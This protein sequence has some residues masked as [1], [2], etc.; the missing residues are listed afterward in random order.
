[1]FLRKLFI[2]GLITLFLIPMAKS[3]AP[4]YKK[5]WAKIDSLNKKLLPK[6]ALTEVNKLYDRAK[7]DQNDAQLIKTLLYKLGLQDNFTEDAPEK[8]IQQ[9]EKEMT[10]LK[11]PAKSI[12]QNLLAEF[13][14]NYFQNNRF[15]IFQRTNTVDFKKTDIATW[16]TGDFHKKIGQLYKASLKNE[17]L[18]QQTKLETFDAL[19]TKGNARNLRPTLFDLLAHK[20]LDYFNNDE[21]DISRPAYAFEISQA[22]AFAPAKEFIKEKFDTKDSGSLHHEAL[23]LYQRL[24]S[25]HITD[26]NP[27]ALVD[28]DLGRLQFAYLYSVSDNKKELYQQALLSLAEQY[29][30]HS[31]A[32]NALVLL[33]KIHYDNTNEDF[34]AYPDGFVKAKEICDKIVMYKDSSFARQE[35]EIMLKEINS[36]QL[37]LQAERVTLPKQAFRVLVTYKNTDNIFV[38]I[39]SLDKKTKTTLQS[40]HYWENDY[41]EELQKISPINSYQQELPA[42]KDYLQHSAEIKVDGLP[43]GEYAIFTSTE[44]DFSIEKS[45]LAVQYVYISSL[46]WLNNDNDF[47]VVNRESGQPQARTNVQVWYRYYDSQKNSYQKRKG[48][49]LITDK[50]GFFHIEESRTNTNNSFSLELS[51][52]G[53]YLFMD[54]TNINSYSRGQKTEEK[55]SYESFLFTDRS[56]YRPGQILYFKGILISKSPKDGK[57]NI[58]AGHETTISLFDINEQKVDSIIV[59]TN[60]FGSYSGKF[61][62]P[63]GQLTGNFRIQ[64]ETSDYSRYFSVE[65]Y[66]RPKF[67]VTINKPEG[68][69]KLNE[70]INV[71]GTAIGYSGAAVNDAKVSYR[72]VR[73]TILPVWAGFYSRR[74]APNFSRQEMEIA[75]GELKTAADGSFTIPFKAIPDASIDKKQQPIF[76]Y[77]IN[78]DI[79]DINGETRSA[80]TLVSVAYQSVKLKLEIPESLSADSLKEIIV[81]STNMNDLFEKSNLTISIQKLSKPTRFFRSRNWTMPDQFLYKE[82]EYHK[83][84]PFDIYKDEDQPANWKKDGDPITVTTSSNPEG[85]IALNKKMSE[86]WYKI[87]VTTTDKDGSIIKEE[88]TIELT[89]TQITNPLTFGSIES[90]RSR[91]EAGDKL[92]YTIK[93][94]LDSIWVIHNINRINKTPEKQFMPV[95]Q[96]GKSFTIETSEADRGGIAL[97]I[98]FIKNNRVYT[99]NT[100]IAIPFSN[101]E[102]SITYS[103]FRDKTLPGKEEKWKVHIKG[104][105]T[106]KVLAEL[107]TTMYDA[108]LDQFKAHKISMPHLWDISASPQIFRGDAGFNTGGNGQEHQPNDPSIDYIEKQY[109]E[110]PIHVGMRVQMMASFNNAV[111]ILKKVP[112]VEADDNQ[113]MAKFVLKSNYME[114][115]VVEGRIARDKPAP[116]EASIK[117]E[118]PIQIRKNFNE[119]AFFLPDLK[120]DSAGD[121]EFSFTMPEAL[122]TWKW[123]SL[124][125][126]KDLAFGYAEKSIITQKDLMVQANAPRFFREGD[127]MDFTAK[128]SNLTDKELVGQIELQLIDPSTNQPVD[129]WFRNF[130]PNQYFT[131][132]PKQSAPAS[133]TIEIPFQYNKPVIYRLIARSGTI[134]DGEEMA[135]PVI[136]NRTLVTESLPINMKGT[137]SKTFRFEKLLQSG[138]SETLAHQSF[139]VEM[140]SNP[141]WYAVQALPYLMEYPYECA[142]QSFNR[143]YSNALAAHIVRS[144][145]RIKKVMD[146]WKAAGSKTFESPLS[147]N[148][149]LKSLLLEET[150][151]VLDAKDEA[152]QRK[153]I[154]LLFDEE[155]LSAEMN[156]WIDKLTQ[157]QTGNGGFPWFQGGPDDAYITQYI[158]TGIGHLKKLNA[159]PADNIKLMLILDKG[160]AYLDKQLKSSY[161]ALVKSKANLNSYQTSRTQIQYLYMRSFFPEKNIPGDIFKAYNYYRSQSKTYWVKESRYTQ[162]MIALSLFRSGEVAV[163]NDIIKSLQQNAITNEEL[164]MYWK[165][166]SNGGFYW[167]QAPIETHCLLLE[168]FAE[169]KKD[170]AITDNLK[171]WLLK[172]KQTTNWRTTKATAEACYA[173]LLTGSNWLN[174][175]PTVSIKA[176]NTDMSASP[177]ETEAGTGYFKKTI[178]G[179]KTAAAM[180]NITVTVSAAPPSPSGEGLGM[181]WGAAYW[182]YFEDLDKITPA[183]TPLK[184]SKKLFVEKNTDKGPVLEP[185]S[186]ER[187][188]HVG[189]K[190]IVRIELRT[191]RNMEYVHLKDMRAASFEPVNVLSGYKWKGGLGYYESTRDAATNFFISYISKGTYVFEYPLFVTHTGTFS[192]GITSIQ[193]MYAPEFGAHSEGIKVRV[194]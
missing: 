22:A 101:K 49:N 23:L 129:G 154:A 75:H 98:A 52:D 48:E 124:A 15:E 25:F 179:S 121:I 31:V 100:T 143:Y 168:A 1:M 148:Q 104:Y 165:D 184:L 155:K 189:E 174:N 47:Y 137:G 147:K 99:D 42:T 191:D 186:E 19:I 156:S 13:Y 109:D 123:M 7:K 45:N 81:S 89:G 115:K 95:T 108:S 141:A 190:V 135:I 176:G 51:K 28:A 114:G 41:W 33:A 149:E 69:Y 151:W 138:N 86:G 85:K 60:E 144:S 72:V 126:T 54:E 82:E 170:N 79:T 24:L 55:P 59:K 163:A 194:E 164:G 93:T 27:D 153:N 34:T 130:F 183:A 83:Y 56:I 162:G 11:E 107:L 63:Q 12:L 36:K 18:L 122:T 26:K 96:N 44:K 3:Q 187:V 152:T 64:D 53:D 43:I 169:I 38:R 167:Y 125:H 2:I 140:T 157:M 150:P 103:T 77:E 97:D 58:V 70:T 131:A 119:T 132:P 142:E 112:S 177:N 73:R 4:A 6:D 71:S 21:Q 105:K 91:L 74:F 172:Q 180:G 20:A 10:L 39:I 66:K 182:Q 117:N 14:L 78:A 88:Q 40:K 30:G 76:N 50:N 29:K 188:L 62:L 118:S 136:S 111:D 57:K 146:A 128:I 90:S 158:L 17:T 145:P 116:I 102:L 106:E 46:A 37:S 159:L 161:D 133:F 160:M 175:E 94:N 113:D 8:S 9:L 166:Y 139:T 5:E 32:N 173:L 65:E 127:R 92:T 178:E 171:T 67:Q 87:E 185:I 181:R 192:N 80:I 16:S 84:F 134:S 120:T 61:V 193:C 68:T 110:M 35:A